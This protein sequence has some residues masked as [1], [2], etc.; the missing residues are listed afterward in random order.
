VPRGGAP[1]PS[2]QQGRG[3]RRHRDHRDHRDA[4][5]LMCVL[6]AEHYRSRRRRAAQCI[7]MVLMGLALGLA[8][9]TKFNS[10]PLSRNC[11]P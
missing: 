7:T 3:G 10:L 4:V 9:I 11:S 8:A 6:L 1:G 2:S 5:A